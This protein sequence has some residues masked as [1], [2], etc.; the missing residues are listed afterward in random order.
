MF[1][2]MSAGVRQD[3]ASGTITVE[4]VQTRCVHARHGR[5]G[6]REVGDDR[7]DPIVTQSAVN[8]GHA[9]L[10]AGSGGHEPTYEN[11]RVTCEDTAP[12]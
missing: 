1:R 11:G 3:F 5:G 9:A 4:T 8:R 2:S 7:R 12:L 6:R 10:L